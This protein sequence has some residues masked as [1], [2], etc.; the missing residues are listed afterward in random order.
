MTRQD[1]SLLEIDLERLKIS[2]EH[3][4]RSN[5]ELQWMQQEDD[6]G[7]YK[8]AIGENIVIICKYRR[9]RNYEQ[10][11]GCRQSDAACPASQSIT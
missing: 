7:E 10:K 4:M 1:V 8:A 9:A 6:D 11:A 2:V 5:K 3:L